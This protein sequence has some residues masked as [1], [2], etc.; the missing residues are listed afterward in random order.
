MMS[1]VSV[2]DNVFVIRE[3]CDETCSEGLSLKLL[4]KE[5]DICFNKK[6]AY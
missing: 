5:G 3:N 4:L 2:N 6:S 1:P